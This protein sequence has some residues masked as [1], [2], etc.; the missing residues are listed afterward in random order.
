MRSTRTTKRQSPTSASMSAS[1]SAQADPAATPR[2]SAASGPRGATKVAGGSTPS[3]LQ[4]AR[5][6]SRQ[7][8]VWKP[9]ARW[10]AMPSSRR[11]RGRSGRIR[12]WSAGANGVWLKCTGVEVGPRAGQRLGD[13]AEV[14][15]LDE[16]DRALGR[17]LGDRG[18]ER[19]V[20]LDVGVPG[21]P[22]VA[23]DHRAAGLVVEA[24]V[25]EPQGGVGHDVV[26]GP[27]GVGVD[28][29]GPEPEALDVDHP[30]TGRLPVGVGHGRRHP[31]GVGAGHERADARDQAAGAPPGH[32]P[33]LLVVAE[34]D[35][36]PVGRPSTT[37]SIDHGEAP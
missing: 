27:V 29:Q 3:A 9:Q 4:Q 11:C 20:D 15:V 21:R 6:R 12:S 14:E 19:L 35:R 34:G 26:E 7:R 25:D 18:G 37:G 10:A 22:P 36:A 23:V 30:L 2:M 31:H 5:K 13:Q 17:D 16:D 1:A 28:G 24:V 8:A 32:Q 33:T